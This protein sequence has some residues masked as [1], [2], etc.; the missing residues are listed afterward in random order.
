MDRYD[1]IENIMTFI[2]G[3]TGINFQLQLKEILAAYYKY[4]GLTYAMPDFY[5]GDQKND[6][7][8]V[9]TATFYQIFSPTRMKDS[10]KKEIENK[11]TTDIEG[12]FRIV[13]EEEKWK[14]NIRQFIF[15]VNTFDGNLPHDSDSYFETLVE[16][17][18]R[19]YGTDVNYIVNNSD[20]IRDLLDEIEDIKVLEKIS[21][22]LRIRHLIDYNAISETIIINLIEEISGNI[23]HKFIG[24]KTFETYNRISSSRKIDINNL[25][26]I[27]DEIENIISKLDVVEN[28][29]KVINQDILF[30]NKFERVKEF[31]VEKY[32]EMSSLYQG[33]ELFHRLISEALSHINN[34]TLAEVSMKFLIIYIFDK[35]DIFEKEKVIIND[36]T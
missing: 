33:E 31:I 24:S 12:L 22:I 19:K 9:E 28:A 25:S 4:K 5:G 15:I 30:E 26:G 3:I 11:F 6:G 36:I 35:C 1:Y 20:Y 14:G 7:W 13:Y 16:K 32:K 8:V 2:K 17:I 18:N 29:V 34:K 23:S 21:A 27:R 10:L